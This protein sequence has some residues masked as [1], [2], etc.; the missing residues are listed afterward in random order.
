[1][2][3][4]LVSACIVIATIVFVAMGAAYVNY[5]VTLQTKGPAPAAPTPLTGYI[6]FNPIGEQNPFSFAANAGAGSAYNVWHMRTPCVFPLTSSADLLQS[7][8][9]TPPT[10]AVV[11]VGITKADNQLQS[12][13]GYRAC[14]VLQAYSGTT[15]YF[16][17][18]T[19]LS[20]DAPLLTQVQTN[21]DIG[22]TGYPEVFFLMDITG[23]PL[24]PVAGVASPVSLTAYIM[25]MDVTLTVTPQAA[26]EVA[27]NSGSGVILWQIS[28]PTAMQAVDI[29]RVYFT[30]NRTNDYV[31][32]TS[33]TMTSFDGTQ[34]RYTSPYSESTTPT[35]D[36]AYFYPTSGQNY[37]FT[38][39][40]ILFKNSPGSNTFI[41]VQLGFQYSFPAAGN[42]YS[43][44][45]TPYFTTVASTGN[46][47]TVVDAGTANTIIIEN[48]A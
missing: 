33:L 43:S 47:G 9:L 1:M 26:L 31:T 3:S 6:G 19:M 30:Q 13:G 39:N 11:N 28:G 42:H 14:L 23:Q 17:I 41:Q 8:I 10:P 5:T 38:Y 29:G 2:P 32:L 48:L 18:P 4:K 20:K 25:T 37:R 35:S 7:A 40:G 46:G 27:P 34:Y 12:S 44:L 15:G 45:I 16:D 36:A 24:S 22:T 21:L